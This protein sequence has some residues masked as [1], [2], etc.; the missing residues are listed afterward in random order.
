MFPL[1]GEGEGSRAR[2]LE[3]MLLSSVVVVDD[4]ADESDDDD[5]EERDG[6]DD[7]KDNS[8]PPLALFP[9]RQL[10]RSAAVSGETEEPSGASVLDVVVAVVVG[11]CVCVGG[12]RDRK[13]RS[14][15]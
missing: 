14:E 7:G 13:E 10:F 8:S 4:D 5:D 15:R 2:A 1:L 12:G 11:L 3:L 6:G 9:R